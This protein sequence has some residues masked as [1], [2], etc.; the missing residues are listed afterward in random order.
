ME[1]PLE[2]YNRLLNEM[3][4][5][6]NL[7]RTRSVN[8]DYKLDYELIEDEKNARFVFEL[9]GM[10]KEEI[11]IELMDDLLVVK[12][13]NQKKN[14]EYKIA[15]KSPLIN[16]KASYKNGILEIIFEKTLKKSKKIKIQ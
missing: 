7:T 1:D 4:N 16:P 15:L 12:G 13:D 5:F 8:T 2:K 14:F 6:T 9:A 11:D 3:F 10:E